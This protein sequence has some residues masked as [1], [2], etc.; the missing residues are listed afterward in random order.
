MPTPI[1]GNQ[2]LSMGSAMGGMGGVSSPL[3]MP[4]ADG[5]SPNQPTM[6]FTYVPVPVYN[7]GGMG[8]PMMPGSGIPSMNYSSMGMIN[9]STGSASPTKQEKSDPQ[10]TA[11]AVDDAEPSSE[12]DVVPDQAGLSREDLPLSPARHVSHPT[13][14]LQQGPV[15]AGPSLLWNV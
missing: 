13:W 1:Q 4:A 7:L 2:F 3:L 9:T 10:Q 12:S 5:S 8:M 11:A 6:A 14:E 15:Q